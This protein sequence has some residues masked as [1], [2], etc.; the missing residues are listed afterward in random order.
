[1]LHVLNLRVLLALGLMMA[2]G[3]AHGGAAASANPDNKKP[4]CGAKSCCA[5][6]S[7]CGTATAAPAASE[8]TE[9]LSGLSAK[10]RAL[11]EKQ[12]ICP[13]TDELLGSMGTPVKITVKGRT[14]FLCCKGC[15]KKIK[16]DPDKY[17]KKLDKKKKK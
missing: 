17:L 2:A 10:D 4:C 1:M 8:D 16:A 3:A 14:V 5:A 7:C 12:R 6:N 11:A 15:E 9:G 13:V